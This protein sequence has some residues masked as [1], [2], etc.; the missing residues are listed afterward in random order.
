MQRRWWFL[1]VVVLC[2]FVIFVLVKKRP[3]LMMRIICTADPTTD[4]ALTLQRITEERNKL[5]RQ[6]NLLQVR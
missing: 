6:H 1:A 5:S 2:F 4:M 3:T